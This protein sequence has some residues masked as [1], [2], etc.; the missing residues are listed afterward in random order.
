M[1]PSG[2]LYVCSD[3]GAGAGLAGAEALRTGGKG[4][5]SRGW[6]RHV[7][8]ARALRMRA[9]ASRLRARLPV[10]V[11]ARAAAAQ[12]LADHQ[13][14]SLRGLPLLQGRHRRRARAGW[15]RDH[16]KRAVAARARHAAE[17]HTGDD[18]GRGARHARQPGARSRL[19]GRRN[20]G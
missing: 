4:V 18:V 2:S 1:T 12:P 7:G 8:E 13:R 3:S 9:M 6:S 17:R 14:R 19:C 15:R 10:R 11:L 5:R 16:L 20:G